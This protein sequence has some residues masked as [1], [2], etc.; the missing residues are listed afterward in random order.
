MFV[1]GYVKKQLMF[2]IQVLKCACIRIPSVEI[3]KH[4]RLLMEKFI[5]QTTC[6]LLISAAVALN[7]FLINS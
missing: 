2:N 6:V 4:L 5:G 1:D 7:F 3:V